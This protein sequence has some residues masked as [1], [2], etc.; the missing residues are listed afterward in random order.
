MKGSFK[1]C[2]LFQKNR[3]ISVFGLALGVTALN[4]GT[5]PNQ[6]QTNNISTIE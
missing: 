3:K 5:K 4:C 2:P 6:T 1:K